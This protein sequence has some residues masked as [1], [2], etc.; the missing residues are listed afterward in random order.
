MLRAPRLGLASLAAFAL[1]GSP[2]FADIVGT[3]GMVTVVTPP[4]SVVQG[5]D[6]SNSTA[7]I[8]A[9]RTTTVP[10]GGLAVDVVSPGTYNGGGPAPDPG[11]IAAGTSVQS[12]LIHSDPGD[13]PVIYTGSVSFNAPILGLEILTGSLNG[14]DSAYGHVGTTYDTSNTARGL[15][16]QDS[17]TLSAN[18]ETL[19]ISFD[20]HDR[21]DE[22]RVFTAAIPEPT[23]LTLAGLGAAVFAAARLRKRARQAQA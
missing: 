21:I 14:T 13:P 8:F 15:E 10:T 9:E 4:P 7:I 16:S 3:T 1:A 2:C 19:T 6:Q 11:T 5:A 20:T 17:I 18:R 22:V 23:A 12:Y